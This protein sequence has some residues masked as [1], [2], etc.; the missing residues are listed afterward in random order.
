MLVY[1]GTDHEKTILAP[2]S[3][4]S[5]R[6]K[7]AQKFGYRRAVQTGSPYVYIYTAYVP[8]FDMEKDPNRDGAYTLR[9]PVKV[10]LDVKFK[11]YDTPHK[12]KDF[13]FKPNLRK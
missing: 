12:L 10:H 4:V 5:K 2:N 11:T 7:E 6:E 8:E 1:H 9:V 3:F 13:N